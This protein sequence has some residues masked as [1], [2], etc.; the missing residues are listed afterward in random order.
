MFRSCC[1]CD[2]EQDLLNVVKERYEC[3]IGL[4]ELVVRSCWIYEFKD[5]PKLRGFV[6][7]VEW[8]DNI[9]LADGEEPDE[10]DNSG[11]IG[12]SE[13]DVDVCELSRV[14]VL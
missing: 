12:D 7:G 5:E 9:T 3:G 1:L 6:N 11:V 10:D 2:L 8:E 4:K 13:G 14:R